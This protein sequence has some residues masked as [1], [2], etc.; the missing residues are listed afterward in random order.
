MQGYNQ[1]IGKLGEKL[2][3]K[4]LKKKG[5]K[6]IE[7]N[8]N[9]RYGE[10]D[11]VATKNNCVAFIEVKTRTSRKFGYPE[12]AINYFKL[13][14]FQNAVQAYLTKNDIGKKEISL[15]AISI[16]MDIKTRKAKITHLENITM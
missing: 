1:K 15:D 14:H 3:A 4:F 6:I 2:A 9:T 7:K 10:I 13:Q 12:Q 16:E 8:F 11:I 5:Y